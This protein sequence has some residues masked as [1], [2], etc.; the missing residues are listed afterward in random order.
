V[1]SPSFVATGATEAQHEPRVVKLVVFGLSVSSAW[2]NGHATLWR[3]LCFALKKLG[4]RVVFFERDVPFYAAHRDALELCGCDVRLYGTWPAV[5]AQAEGELADADAAIITSYCPDA[6]EAVQTVFASAV[7]VRAF[8]DLDTPIT[9]RALHEGADVPYV[10][11]DGLGAF[12]VVLSYTGG[13]ALDELMRVLGATRVAPLYGSVDP[14]AHAPVAPSAAF[15]ADLSYL[16][17]YA[18][19]RHA[20]FERLFRSVARARPR[21][22]F[23]LGGA[24]YPASCDL[25]ANVRHFSHV[26]P[27]D[28]PSFYCSSSM[29]LNITREAMAAYGYCP[30]G[31]L[32][33]AAACGVPILSDAWRGIDEFFEAGREILIA[34]DTES[35]LA[36]LATSP[37]ELQSLARRARERTLA[38]HTAARRAEQLLAI[39]FEER[40][41]AAATAVN[42]VPAARAA[43]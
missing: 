27:S 32:F 8:Y 14:H 33:E 19:D 13:G 34:T 2:G 5:C 16:G 12:D 26:R 3:G 17:T 22:T 4:H 40:G 41:I 10:P 36:A 39:L 7:P 9:L 42:D 24:Q 25:P 20:A 15:A 6:R 43:S 18:A 37:S 30:S 1:W 28:H 29:T 35:A 38:E 23:V 21:S 31:R 11:E